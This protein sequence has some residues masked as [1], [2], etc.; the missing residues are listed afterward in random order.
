MN[1]PHIC[2]PR[3]AVTRSLEIRTATT[4]F[5]IDQLRAALNSEHSLKAGRPAGNTIWQGIYETDLDEGYPVLCAVLC[6][7]GAAL[8]L[9]DRDEWID[10]DPLTR[11]SRL[12]LITQLRRFL[13]LQSRR[14][15]NLA[16]RCMG[17]ALRALPGHFEQKYGYRPLLAESFS[18]PQ[19]HEGTIYKASNWTPLGFSKGYRRH[20]SEFYI[21]EKSPKKYWVYPLHKNSQ[22]LLSGPSPLTEIYQ[23]GTCEGVA[24]ARCALAHKH[25]RSLSDAFYNVPD[26]RS[27]FSRR[28]A[29]IAMFGLIA[30]GLLVGAPNV[31][32][33]WKR[34][35]ALSQG[36]RKAIGLNVRSKSG[37]LV[38]P[39]YDALNNFINGIDPVALAAAL[40]QW[41]AV[42]QDK[43]PKSLA[44]DGK[45]LG[46]S[47]GAIVTLCKHE[48]GRPVAMASYS[49]EKDD[50]ELPVAQKLL[51]E[52][53]PLLE[54]A[55]I[56]S[57]ALHT[58]KNE[59]H[60][61]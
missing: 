38:M 37:N 30:H 50:C 14:K 13:V 29:K 21:D 39:G 47:L 22:K 26:H 54:N 25:L 1:S 33:I 16:T 49:G 51:E 42:H 56:T 5:E 43:L 7:S 4:K 23:K 18:D 53:A 57:D 60:H 20:K 3:D 12:P 46:H 31:K 34:C 11:G 2:S 44:L 19:I 32:A 17:L 8:R 6:W 41:L 55:T 9:K 36:Q 15:P 52:S 24:G 45:D 10:W 28:Y 59:F 40:N 35:A 58:Q 27:P 48:D 61:I